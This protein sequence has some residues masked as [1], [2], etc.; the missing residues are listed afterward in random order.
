MLAQY[1]WLAFIKHGFIVGLFFLLIH[2]GHRV[3]LFDRDSLWNSLCS[4]GE[5]KCPCCDPW[6]N[7]QPVPSWRDQISSQMSRALSSD[8]CIS[9]SAVYLYLPYVLE[10]ENGNHSSALAMK[11]PWMAEAEFRLPSSLGLQRAGRNLETEQQQSYVYNL[12]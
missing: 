6:G 12:L 10:K 7:S 3:V 5:R 8:I 11:T 9:L 4:V 2:N 1:S